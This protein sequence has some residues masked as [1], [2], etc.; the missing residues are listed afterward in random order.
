MRTMQ[1]V[2]RWIGLAL[3]SIGFTGGATVAAM[4]APADNGACLGCHGSNSQK[5][6]IPGPDGKPRALKVFA[7]DAFSAGEHGKLQCVSCHTTIKESPESGA[8]HQKDSASVRPAGCPDCH[9]R[10]WDEAVKNNTA[11]SRPGLRKVVANIE[12]YKKSFHARPGKDDK[13]KPLATCDNCHNTHTFHVPPPGSAVHVKWRQSIPKFCGE[14]HSEQL[15]TYTDSVHGKEVLGKGNEK[16]AVCADCHTSHAITN[17]SAESFK[18]SVTATCGNCHSAQYKSYKATFHGQIS[19]LGYGYT[20]KC[21]NCHGSHGVQRVK[22]PASKAHADNRMETCKECHNGKKAVAAPASFASFQ[23]HATTDNFARYPQVW[24]AFKLMVGLLLGTFGFFWL[25]TALWFYREFKERKA[26]TLRPH[27]KVEALPQD[28]QGKHFRRFSG[29]WR[30]A[31]I[32]FALSLMILTLTGMP[33]FYA[34]APWASWVMNA[35]GGPRTAG[36]IH[37]AAAIVFAGV[38][39]WHLF[40]VA[41]YLWRNRKTFRIF[42]PTSLVPGLQDLTDIIAM[43]KWFFGLAPRPVF[44]RWTYWEKFDYWAPFWGVTII[45]VSGLIMWLPHLTGTLLPG[46]VFNVAAIFHGEEAFLAVV[47]LFTVHFFN[48]HFRPE[49]FPVDVVM[50][51]GTLSLEHVMREHPLEYKRLKESGEL[52]KY[53]VDA[54][55][56]PMTLASKILGFTLISFGLTLLFGVAVGFFGSL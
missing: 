41:L 42:G 14:C 36:T 5:I 23:P 1:R 50:F 44:D 46:W 6:E 25:H 9:Q 47:F 55:S 15:E 27:V 34:E 28:Q 2:G 48:N 35:L 49:K 17:T 13:S 11:D 51:T 4:A 33:L 56:A 7:P 8:G 22:D 39:F 45:G 21:Y 30:L 19:S 12:A 32:T 38:F 43:F 3:L 26:Q 29:I 18:L 20:A 53:I 40:Y 54:P 16:A 52:D 37:R 24:L 31:H 10:L